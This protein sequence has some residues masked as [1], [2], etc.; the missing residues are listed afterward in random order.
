MFVCLYK[1][2]Q[3]LLVLKY[4]GLSNIQLRSFI[5]KEHLAK[6]FSFSFLFP[7]VFDQN[8]CTLLFV[9]GL[10][11]KLTAPKLEAND[12]IT[13]K[14]DES[15]SIKC[16]AES[17]PKADIT[18][19]IG[20]TLLQGDVQTSSPKENK[21]ISTISFTAQKSYDKMTLHCSGN[22]TFTYVNSSRVTLNIQ[23]KYANK[24]L[25]TL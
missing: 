20:G 22:D 6:R 1:A 23:C 14:E 8:N 4:N 3:H 17:I 2:F 7:F 19:Y 5:L 25:V 16:T 13:R 11:E 21:V 24:Y 9:T 18:W 12:T 15:I 10:L